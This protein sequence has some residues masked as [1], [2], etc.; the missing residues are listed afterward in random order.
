MSL[1]VFVIVMKP[2]TLRHLL[3]ETEYSRPNHYIGPITWVAHQH[4]ML[5][6]L[7][8]RGQDVPAHALSQA[9]STMDQLGTRETGSNWNWPYP[10]G[11]S[12]A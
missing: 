8:T 1:F 4:W 10:P 7:S 9:H 3:A 11:D 12:V 2:K 6:G 5:F